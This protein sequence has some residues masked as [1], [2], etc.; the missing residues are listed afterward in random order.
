MLQVRQ[1]TTTLGARGPEILSGVDL[2]LGSGEVLGVVGES[3]SGKSM[4]ALSIMGLLP[5]PIMVR[6]GQV[7]LQGQD[8]LALPPRQMRALRGKD[9]AMIFQE[10]MT[11]LNPV[12]RVGQQIG[13]VLRWHLSLQG[14]AARAEGIAL[15]R[16]VEM[17]DPQRQIDAYPHELSGGMRQRVMIAMA[18]AGRPRLL[19]ADE[20]TTALD[21]TIQ[22]Q[23]LNLLRKLQQ[24][25]GMSVLLITHDLGVI[26]EMCDRVAVMYAGRVVEQGAVLDIFD[27]PAHPYTRGLLASR[28]KISAGAQWL[29][30]IEGTVP[31][32]GQ[33]GPG[34]S[35]A[36][37]CPLARTACTSVPALREV[38][39][40]H[41][42]ACVV[43][44][45]T[46]VTA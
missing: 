28:P 39:P 16:R 30:T 1:L 36:P 13:E 31:A 38:G 27:R 15:L 33:M 17:P 11:S 42:A 7:H 19:I 34:C 4:L 40:G 5:H 29:S 21:V 14:D 2:A 37:R 22:S 3:G 24:D 46:A 10:P 23:I 44:F 45:E 43:P 9:V 20:P 32:L 25:S 8:L 41:Q 35:F 26:A 6:N 18:L 12:M